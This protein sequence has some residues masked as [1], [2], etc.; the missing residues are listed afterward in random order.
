MCG[1]I[2]RP[3]FSREEGKVAQRRGLWRRKERKRLKIEDGQSQFFANKIDKSLAIVFKRKDANNIRNKMEPN[4]KSRKCLE[5]ICLFVCLL[6]LEDIFKMPLRH[7][8]GTPG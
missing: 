8:G 1:K 7:P 2:Y 3:A 6:C 5:D 4:S